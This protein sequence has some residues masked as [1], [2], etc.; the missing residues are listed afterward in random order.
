MHVNEYVHPA[1]RIPREFKQK[2]LDRWKN[3]NDKRENL[4]IKNHLDDLV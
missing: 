3:Q 4:A 1:E 2:D